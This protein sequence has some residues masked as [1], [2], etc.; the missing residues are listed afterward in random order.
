[1]G[2]EEFPCPDPFCDRCAE[3]GPEFQAVGIVLRY[4]EDRITDIETIRGNQPQ[5]IAK[6]LV[7]SEL[8]LSKDV[9]YNLRKGERYLTAEELVRFLQ[10]PI[11]GLDLMTVLSNSAML[12]TVTEQWRSDGGQLH[13]DARTLRH[14]KFHPWTP[15]DFAVIVDARRRLA[16]DPKTD[17]K[18]ALTDVTEAITHLVALAAQLQ[19]THGARDPDAVDWH[20]E[21][22]RLQSMRVI[23]EADTSGSLRQQ[24]LGAI[25]AEGTSTRTI[26]AAL[27]LRGVEA[28]PRAIAQATSGLHRSGHIEPTGVRGVW[29]RT[30]TG[31]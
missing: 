23:A 11:L 29:R 13:Y 12:R 26:R 20:Y 5:G 10:H 28:S 27:E 24:V 4:A 16:M 15:V 2:L 8:Q 17:D 6:R 30:T 22:Q 3:A 31:Q 9:F 18:Q 19:R 25:G 1:M 14:S 21:Q 7:R